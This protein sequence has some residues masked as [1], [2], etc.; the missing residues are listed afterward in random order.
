MFAT[1]Q[2][3]NEAKRKLIAD[4]WV[5]IMG[6]MTDGNTKNYGSLFDKDGQTFYLNH[7]TALSV[8]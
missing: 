2:Q 7:E 3:I 4:G 1:T 6:I 5:Y 8:L